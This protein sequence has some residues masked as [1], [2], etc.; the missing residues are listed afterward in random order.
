[1][2]NLAAHTFM[3]H[4]QKVHIFNDCEC[5]KS[6]CNNGISSVGVCLLVFR[7]NACTDA[8]YVIDKF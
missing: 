6:L 1:M 4:Y 5:F 2:P 8:L 3:Y 7:K